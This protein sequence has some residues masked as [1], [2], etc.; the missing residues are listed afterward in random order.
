MTTTFIANP[1]ATPQDAAAVADGRV[2]LATR[3][4]LQAFG[5]WDARLLWECALAVPEPRFYR[6]PRR[7]L[8]HRQDAASG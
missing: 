5:M 7:I 4:R 6:V 2:F 1:G 8:R 3:T